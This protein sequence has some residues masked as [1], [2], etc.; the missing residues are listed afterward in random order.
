MI[1]LW[2]GIECG[3]KCIGTL[4]QRDNNRHDVKWEKNCNFMNKEKTSQME[5]GEHMTERESFFGLLTIL[6]RVCA[7]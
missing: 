3:I 4:E 6:V 1:S 5:M 7:N 2:I